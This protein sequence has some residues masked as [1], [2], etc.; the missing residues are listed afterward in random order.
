MT[1]TF[2]KDP[3]AKLDYSFDWREWLIAEQ[4]AS[5]TLLIDPVTPGTGLSVADTP[6]PTQNFG[7]VTFWLQGGVDSDTYNVTCRV[8]TTEGRTDDRTMKIKIKQL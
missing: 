5:F 7:I 4:I 6:A 1:T 2:N 3:Q 8:T